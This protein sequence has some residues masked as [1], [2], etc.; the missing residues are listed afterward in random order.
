MSPR[1]HH[2]YGLRSVSH[3]CLT[4]GV[5]IRP[6]QIPLR[7]DQLV[8]CERKLLTKVINHN[9]GPGPCDERFPFPYEDEQKRTAQS[10]M[11]VCSAQLSHHLE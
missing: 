3:F 2:N 6:P 11:N 7:A 4:S 10:A 8:L 9:S 1:C 5:I